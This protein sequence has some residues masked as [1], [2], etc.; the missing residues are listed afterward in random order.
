MEDDIDETTAFQK[1]ND[2]IR[3][4]EEPGVETKL[5]YENIAYNNSETKQDAA[6]DTKLTTFRN[7]SVVCI[8]FLLLFSAFLS[9][10]NLQSSINV[11]EGL[12]TTGLTFVFITK[13]MS[14]L[15]LPPLVLSKMGMKWTMCISMFGYIAYIGASFHA[16]W[17]T[18]V[19]TSFLLGVGA[20]N[21]WPAQMNYVTELCRRHTN[22]YTELR[23]SEALS[24]FFGIFFAVFHTGNFL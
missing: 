1:D 4:A 5:T 19:P 6:L 22:I 17:S 14:S 16:S 8:S 20:S 24:R 3:D 18:I 23:Q 13:V 21:L 15:F 2:K 11:A 10:A 7:L 9:L 12:G